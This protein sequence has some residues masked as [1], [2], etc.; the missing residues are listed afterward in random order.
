MMASDDIWGKLVYLLRNVDSIQANHSVTGTI[1]ISDQNILDVVNECHFS[2]DVKLEITS[3]E[4]CANLAVGHSIDISCYPRIGWGRIA[5]D[6]DALLK[7]PKAYIKEPRRY[8]L[9]LPEFTAMTDDVSDNSVIYKYR[10]I[11]E[12]IGVLREAAAFLNE[13]EQCLVLIN[14]GRFDIP[15]LYDESDLEGVI[16]SDIEKAI[17]AFPDGLHRKQC[18]TIMAEAIIA[19]TKS[20]P[21]SKRFKYLLEHLSDVLKRY[22][23]GYQL[24]ASGFSYEKIKDQVETTRIEYTSKIHKVLSD[25]QNQLLGLPV[26]TIIVATQMKQSAN[27]ETALWVN[28]AVLFGIW[29]FSLLMSFLIF[30]QNCTLNVIK[31]EI[32]RQKKQLITEFPA[33]ENSFKPVFSYLFRRIK[34][35]KIILV[36]LFVILAIALIGSH[37]IYFSFTH[38]AYEALQS[39]VAS[40]LMWIKC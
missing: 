1:R 34:N 25:I 23:D 4:D 30:N 20:Q 18:Q 36:A 22:E 14:S 24:F 37:F 29:I 15:I 28:S 19:L 2:E 40:I 7:T 27:S 5:N 6:L 9:L 21:E 16:L 3:G 32:S 13:E 39:F 33:I 35:Q 26:A 12:L 10:K 17:A 8:I 11:I 31:D 38:S